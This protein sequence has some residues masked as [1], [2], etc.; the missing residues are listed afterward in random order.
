MDKINGNSVE[1]V[2]PAGALFQTPSDETPEAR[3]LFIRQYDRT[4]LQSCRAVEENRGVKVARNRQP[5]APGPRGPAV[6]PRS[7]RWPPR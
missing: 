6:G 3:L 7:C 5:G 2:R 1:S 4:S